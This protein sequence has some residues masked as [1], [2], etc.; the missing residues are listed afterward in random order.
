M[1]LTPVTRTLA[2]PH[3]MRSADRE[4][5]RFI[6]QAFARPLPGNPRVE[7]DDKGWTLNLDLPGIPREQLV[8]E[9]EDAV[10]RVH[11]T[12]GA[13]RAFKVAYELPEALDTQASS[14]R[15]ENGVLTLALLKKAPE[16]RARQIEVK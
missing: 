5:Q 16:S 7:Q 11:T 12:E 2:Y 8:V 14:A 15:L 1:F 4:F 6:G 13:T 9:I 3:A 10:V